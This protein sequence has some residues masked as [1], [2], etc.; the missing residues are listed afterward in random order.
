M[1][2]SPQDHVISLGCELP[3]ALF[4]LFIA[5]TVMASGAL[6]QTQTTAIN[7]ATQSRNPDFSSFPFTR[8]TSVGTTLPTTCQVGQLFF[9]TSAVPGTNLY[10]CT[11]PNSWTTLVSGSIPTA[12]ATLTAASLSFA[13]QT[14]GT[15]SAARNITLTNTGTSYLTLSGIA[16]AGGNSTDFVVSN[17]CGNIVPSGASC[18][19]AVSFKPS[20]VGAEGSIIAVSGTQSGSPTQINISGTGTAAITSGGL[21]ITPSATYARENGTLAFTSNRPVNWSLATGSSGTLI[22]SSSTSATYSAPASIP[23][24]NVVGSCQATPNDSVYNTRID[25]LPLEAHSATWASNMGSLGISFLTSWGT[26]IADSTTPVQNMSFYYTTSYNGP[27]VLPQWPALKRENGTFG[28]RLNDTDHHILTVRKDNCQFYETYNNYFTPATCRDGVTQGCNAQ[29]GLTYAWNSYA[30][31]SSGSTDAAG[32]PLGPLTLR[33]DEIKSGVIHHAMRFTVAGGFIQALPYWPANSGNGCA[34]CV[35]SPPYGARF[36]LKANFDISTFSPAAQVVLTALQQYGMFL[37]DAGTGP[38][39]TTSTDITEDPSTMSA[40]GQIANAQIN[41][42]NFE[43]VDESSFIVS[44]SSGQVNPA[45]PY[46]VPNSFALLTATDQTNATYQVTYPVALQSVI[47]GIPSPTLTIL[48]GMSGYQLTSWVTGATNQSTTWSL[49]SGPGS[50]TATGV[51]TP[52]PSVSTP[53]SAILQATSAADPSAFAKLYLT[54]LPVGSNPAGSIRIDS[55]N[56][57]S[58]TDGSGNIWLADQAFETGAYVQLAGDYPNWTSLNGNAERNVYQSSGHT[59]G[60]DIV[61]SL[62]VPNGNYKVRVMLGQ[63]YNGCSAPCGTFN[64]AW[65]APL[66]IEANGQIALHNY[67]FGL[68]ISYAFATPVDVFI[69]AQVTNNS[70][71]VALR[72]NLPDVPTQS[73]PSPA[74]NGLEIIPDSTSPYLVIDTQQQTSVNAGSTLQLYSVGWY[75]GNAV[76]WSVSGPG[77]ISQSGLYTAPATASASSQAVTIRATSTVSPSVQATAILTIPASGS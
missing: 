38:T 76:T 57:S 33:L 17:T 11:A 45:N 40:L 34:G 50:V 32:L 44:N 66:H 52:P 63:P 12:Q 48:A 72:I 56:P 14:A 71:Y 30:L 53:T 65:H 37:A 35:N 49:V 6:A 13:S 4:L 77:S 19:I 22:S 58:T 51:Y 61:Y 62:I 54:V 47:V 59:Y 3:P 36:R 69:P 39:I 1:I 74:I 16:L 46:E 21:V 68:P 23:A 2:N 10:G 43:A 8:P 60:N 42:T 27:F 24:Q 7:L 28:T 73:Q 9:K 25:N 18:S 75:M 64:P 67:D 26:N 29:S 41:M 31:P 55:G 20:L 70:L 5:A 15:T